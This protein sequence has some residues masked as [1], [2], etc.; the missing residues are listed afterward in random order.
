MRRVVDEAYICLGLPA[1]SQ[2]LGFHLGCA[3][4]TPRPRLTSSLSAALTESC[5][6]ARRPLGGKV[7]FLRQ[8]V[9]CLSCRFDPHTDTHVA[10]FSFSLKLSSRPGSLPKGPRS[11]SSECMCGAGSSRPL[12]G[13]PRRAW[14]VGFLSSSISWSG[15]AVAE[16]VLT[17]LSSPFVQAD[18]SLPCQSA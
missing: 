15:G 16:T 1:Y 9:F 13:R 7:L 17:S 11:L 4:P 2:W 5:L 12:T 6:F 10:V 14:A 3:D 8:I 18:V